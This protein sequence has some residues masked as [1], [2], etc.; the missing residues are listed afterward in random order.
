M[1]NALDILKE[2]GFIY[3]ITDEE[4]MHKRLAEGPATF[5]V[6]FDPT[7][8]SLHIGHLLPVMAMRWLQKAGHRPIALVGGGTAMIGD[9]SG[10]TEARPIS[11]VA[12]IDANAKAIQAQLGRFLDFSPGKAVM[13][14]NADWLR[15]LKLIDFLRDIGRLFSIPRMLS[16]ESV[17][18]RLET[19]LSFLEFSYPLLQSY[20]FYILRRDHGCQFQFGGQD[21]WG[22][23]VAGVDLTRRLLS[24]EVFGATFPLLLKSDGTK[25]GKTAGGAVWLD[26]ERTA[27]FDYYQFWRNVD[28]ADVTRLLS[29][30][31]SLPMEEVR[32][33][34][35]LEAPQ[36]NRSKEILAY[37]AT[38]LA[39][40]HDEAMRA[41]L[42]A[43]Q[44]FGFADPDGA[45]ETSSRITDLPAGGLDSDIPTLSLTAAELGDGIGVLTL[46][47]KAGLC[48]SNGEARRLIKGGGCYLD[49]ARIS[50]E[51]AIIT[52]ADFTDG[53]LTLRA[54]KKARK[55][56]LLAS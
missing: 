4:A 47:V 8:N 38:A 40:G 48:A 51:K 50:D 19:G 49:D 6:G 46:L 17:Q 36:I 5:Y 14:N 26:A 1:T 34:G 55:R 41:F 16:A 20:D 54:G 2:R 7:G 52:A 39:H 13:V 25:F 22:N 18:L 45:I 32:R 12:T 9:P 29:F 27:P 37:E 30:F 15:G 35:S 3:Q 31:T 28:D 10:K 56:V 23:I 11:D 33:L 24:E 53:A 21:Q 42:A 44:E 43:G